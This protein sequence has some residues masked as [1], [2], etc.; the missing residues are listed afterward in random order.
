MSGDSL[1]VIYATRYVDKEIYVK[2]IMMLTVPVKE[3]LI[4][5]AEK[6]PLLTEFHK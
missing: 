4:V 3:F 2:E 1:F 5:L 6:L